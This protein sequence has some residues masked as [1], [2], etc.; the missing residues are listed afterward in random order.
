[1]NS[2]L[3]EKVQSIN[4]KSSIESLMFTDRL[5]TVEFHDVVMTDISPE[6]FS[7]AVSRLQEARFIKARLTKQQFNAVMSKIT[8]VSRL[9]RLRELQ[10]ALPAV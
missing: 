8:N 9:K 6:M 4:M 10:R 3:S 7:T 5:A 2:L 1:M